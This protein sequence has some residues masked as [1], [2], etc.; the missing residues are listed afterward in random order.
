M[1]IAE[2]FNER[3]IAR[4]DTALER[5]CMTF[6][7]TFAHHGARTFVAKRI[8][9]CAKSRTQT[10]DGLTEAGN[11]AVAELLTR[12]RG[13]ALADERGLSA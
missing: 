1:L 4:M 5:A 9:E 2:Q 13:M 10:L 7:E 11:L 6:P 8:V 12:E 3:T